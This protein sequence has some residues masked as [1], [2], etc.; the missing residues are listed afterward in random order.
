MNV[1]LFTENGN[2]REDRNVVGLKDIVLASDSVIENAEK[3][4]SKSGG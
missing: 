2:L 1:D 3:S 4:D